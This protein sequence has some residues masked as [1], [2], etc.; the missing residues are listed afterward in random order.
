MAIQLSSNAF[1]NGGTIPLKYSCD[2]E[3][4]SPDLSWSGLP[5]GAKSLA[6]IMDDPDAPAGTWVHWVLYNLPP[7]TASLA[8]GVQGLGVAGTNSSRQT[9]YGGPCP[10]K[11]KPHR[12]FFKLY[13]L[14]NS[15]ELSP[16]ATKAA[17]EK[18][19]QG[20]VLGAGQLMG[21]YGR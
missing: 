4:V 8:E 13:S 3:N 21:T 18:A 11:G 20:H 2:G 9:S 7:D 17:V 14:D 6:L 10:P 5:E 1:S 16:G 15:L 12:Y 19:M